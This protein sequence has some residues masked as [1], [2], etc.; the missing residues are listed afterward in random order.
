MQ[1]HMLG[2]AA[3]I[4]AAG[5]PHRL[6]AHRSA[7]QLPRPQK[8]SQSA[9]R[10]AQAMVEFALALPI[11]L[12][13]VYGLLEVGRVIFT[14]SSVAT[15]SREA[16]RYASATGLISTTGSPI[17]S[18]Q[19]CAGIRNTARRVGFLL[20]LQDNQIRIY[21]DRP[22]ATPTPVPITEYCQPGY[23]SSALALN[24]GDRVF[25]NVTTQ[26]NLIVPIVPLSSRTISSGDTART[27]M[28]VIDLSPTPTP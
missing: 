9:A 3:E 12:L 11:F 17:R 20:N 10:S 22:N 19:D 25:V 21:Y 13:L 2:H 23:T 15:A 7:S 4:F 27:F 28:G 26:W 6:T 1:S 5:N 14:I 16:V 24:P 18:Y 8:A